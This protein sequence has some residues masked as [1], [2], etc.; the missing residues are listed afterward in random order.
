MNEQ[1]NIKI[2]LFDMEGTLFQGVG[3]RAD[4][5]PATSAWALLA[6]RMGTEVNVAEF[7]N[8][9]KWQRGEY[10]SY[11]AWM[12]DTSRLFKKEGMTKEFFDRT[13]DSIDYF[14]GVKEV[15]S[16]L[17]ERGI[18][19]GV[20]TGGFY[21]LAERALRELGLHHAYAS[22]RYFWDE[23]EKLSHWE[24]EEH[25]LEGKIHAAKKITSLY[26]VP[27]EN[28]AFVGDGSNDVHVARI[29]GTSIAFNGVKELSDMTT[30]AVD[31]EKGQEDFRA[32]LEYI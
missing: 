16:T 8:Y 30:Y 28:C 12:E 31:Q 20:I 19:T 14:P 10:S 23:N 32:I 3:T 2:V 18:H 11:S 29:V 22:S 1:K 27:L 17:H 6:D 4:G 9:K 26:D 24:L 21:E 7:E 13:L 15:L 5:M 25:G